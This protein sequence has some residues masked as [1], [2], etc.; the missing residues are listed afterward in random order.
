MSN[1][2]NPSRFGKYLVY[3]LKSRWSENRAFMIL[4]VIFPVICYS[5]W[6]FFTVLGNGFSSGFS[7]FHVGHPSIATRSGIF[8]MVSILFMIFYP[9]KAYGFI[10]EKAKGSAWIELPASRFEKYL[11]MMLITLAII[12]I[13]FFIGY[14]FFDWIICVADKGCGASLV[15]AWLDNLPSEE[16]GVMVWGYGTWGLV[17]L[18]LQTASVF[19]LGALIFKKAKVS[20]TILAL[21]VVFMVFFALSALIFSHI[22][23]DSFGERMRAWVMDHI[24]SIDTWINFWGNIELA[25]IVIGL[26]IWSWFRVKNIQH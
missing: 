26:G 8:A 23:L 5:V 17:S 2:F 25:V 12:P 10:T 11:S 9:S 6:V 18:I 24:D 20:R 13:I 14:L 1:T 16:D 21:F 19:L 22:N 15:S 7:D 4:W 3:D